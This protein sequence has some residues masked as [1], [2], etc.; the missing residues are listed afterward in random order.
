MTTGYNPAWVELCAGL[1]VIESYCSPLRVSLLGTRSIG[2]LIGR[3]QD[4]LRKWWD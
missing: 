1:T 2:F 4:P 3:E